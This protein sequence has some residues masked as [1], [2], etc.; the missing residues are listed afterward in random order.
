MRWL[1]SCTTVQDVVAMRLWADL[2]AAALRHGDL[3]AAAERLAELGIAAR[4]AQTDA[5]CVMR[6]LRGRCLDGRGLGEAIQAHCV[7]VRAEG[8][9]ITRVDVNWPSFLPPVLAVTVHRVAQAALN[10]AHARQATLASVEVDAQHGGIALLVV[11]DG[12]VN[13][14]ARSQDSSG[15]VRWAAR[16]PTL[17][18]HLELLT[19]PGQQRVMCWLP[20]DHTAIGG[21]RS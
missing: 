6:G 13:E 16:V 5:R 3:E 14:T 18:G 11:D 21:P 8:G 12:Y 1:P 9:P 4:E 10:D 20:L 19:T 2:A 7:A 17:G 15:L